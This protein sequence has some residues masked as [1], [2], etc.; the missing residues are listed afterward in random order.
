MTCLQVGVNFESLQRRVTDLRDIL[1]KVLAEDRGEGVVL[2]FLPVSVLAVASILAA[3]ASGV[4]H[5]LVFAG[6]SSQALH[7]LLDTG[8]VRCVLTDHEHCHKVQTLLQDPSL[9]QGNI[10]LIY[11]DNGKRDFISDLEN[12]HIDPIFALYT[13]GPS[14]LI[15]GENI[16]PRVRKEMMWFLGTGEL[17]GFYQATSCVQPQRDDN[18]GDIIKASGDEEELGKQPS[19]FEQ[20][21]KNDYRLPYI[22]DILNDK[23]DQER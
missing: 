4:R 23:K 15:A 8:L 22:K 10:S 12:Y 16:C 2:M 3:T 11:L 1:D 13:G 6:F 5:S 7:Q 14:S 20:K 21:L 17:T 9:R 18:P 19:F